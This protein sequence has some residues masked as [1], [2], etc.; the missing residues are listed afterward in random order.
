MRPGTRPVRRETAGRMPAS[1]GQGNSFAGVP[2]AQGNPAGQESAA[3]NQP[4]AG[5][6]DA[7]LPENG[8]QDAAGT[9][10]TAAANAAAPPGTI[11]EDSRKRR[12]NR[13]SF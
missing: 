6:E 7:E 8:S 1:A 9:D 11:G 12:R 5:E 3:G 13:H 10:M 4:G 2:G